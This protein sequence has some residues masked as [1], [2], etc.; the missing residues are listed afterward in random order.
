MRPRPKPIDPHAVLGVA[1]GAGKAEIRRA[2][3]RRALAVHPDVAGL[4]ATAAMAALNH[5][6]DQLL[7]RGP[8]GAPG[9]SADP[10]TARPTGAE[11]RPRPGWASA[12]TSAWTDHW[13]AWN[14]LPR[15]DEP[16]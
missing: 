13:S 3:R 2:Y 11:P 12:H 6:R 7:S 14:E 8:A 10:E 16:R 15:R 5:A 9:P 4:E 1:P